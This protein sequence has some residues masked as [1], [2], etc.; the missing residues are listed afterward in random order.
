MS[1]VGMSKMKINMNKND[2]VNMETDRE[3]GERGERKGKREGKE[4][5]MCKTNM[6]GKTLS[7]LGTFN[8]QMTCNLIHL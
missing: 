6:V 4:R 7:T 1:K 3:G 2:K 5:I 8:S